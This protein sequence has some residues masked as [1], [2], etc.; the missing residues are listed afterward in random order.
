MVIKVK[1]KTILK[2]TKLKKKKIIQ[3]IFK[4]RIKEKK[5]IIIELQ[6]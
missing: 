2:R 5:N 3:I 6:K 4:K 1:T